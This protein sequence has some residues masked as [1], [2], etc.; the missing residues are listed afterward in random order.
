MTGCDNIKNKGF[1][2][3]SQ[4]FLNIK[5]NP[6]NTVEDIIYKRNLKILRVAAG[7]ALLADIFWLIVNISKPADAKIYENLVLTIGYIHIGFSAYITLLAFLVKKDYSRPFV[8]CSIYLY[9][10]FI[11]FHVAVYANNLCM[12]ALEVG[13]STEF[14]GITLSTFYLFILAFAPIHNKRASIVLCILISI[15]CVVPAF[16]IY[17]EA[18]SLTDQI[19]LRVFIISA[20]ILLRG[21]N[22]R[23]AI[24]DIESSKLTSNLL[25]TTYTDHLT[26]VLNRRAMDEYWNKLVESPEIENVGVLIFD[27]D[28][29]KKYNDTYSHL[30]GDEALQ[31]VSSKVCEVLGNTD[32]FLFRY[33]GEEFI[34]LIPNTTV[35]D[36]KTIAVSIVDAVYKAN[37]PR[38][39]SVYDRL[40]VTVGGEISTAL[41]QN[42]ET[43]IK[44]ADK[45]LYIGKDGGKN[46]YVYNG[47]I[48]RP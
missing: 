42:T 9:Y 35:E 48:Y 43:Y 14:M 15:G 16:S 21:L 30:K 34:S 24:Q 41:E 10:V 1:E 3:F 7:L 33:G 38:N 23:I 39:D 8:K 27:I 31:N 19:I 5:N 25:I 28:F 18:Y 6:N 32:N 47:V 37:F 20:Y 26:G 13:A 45:Q 36:L 46:C 4:Q 40:T 12:R 44:E 17:K 22:E 29:F 2:E 11:I